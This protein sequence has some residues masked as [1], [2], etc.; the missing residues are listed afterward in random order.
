MAR[1]GCFLDDFPGFAAWADQ[2]G[3]GRD[4]SGDVWLV[5]VSCRSVRI[6]PGGVVTIQ[7]DG[8]GST[9]WLADVLRGGALPALVAVPA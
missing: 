7:P 4:R 5:D 6:T 9:A 3:V 8:S 1:P 2:S